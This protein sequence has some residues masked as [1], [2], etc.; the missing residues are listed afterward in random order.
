[1]L[2]GVM[3]GLVFCVFLMA[4]GL[5]RVYQYYNFYRHVH[6][7]SAWPAT[8]GTVVDGFTGY[9]PGMRGGKIYYAVMQYHYHV[10][11]AKYMGELKKHTFWGERAAKRIAVKHPADSTIQIHYNPAQPKEHV[12]VL[13]KSTFY[14]A[15]SL[16]VFLF[17]ILGII[18]AFVARG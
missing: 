8:T 15:V 5:Y 16:A 1:M 9:T 12:S 14:L 11:G 10:Q 2:P 17:G 4:F 6:S 18:A 13:D 3:V 7:G